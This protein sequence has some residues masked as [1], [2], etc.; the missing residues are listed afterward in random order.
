VN[1]YNRT[2]VGLDVH[3][4]TIVT[5]VLP[6]WSE[7]VTETARVENTREVIEKLV[8]RLGSQGAVEFVYEAGPCGYEVQRQIQNLG[9]SCFVVAPGLIPV[10][11]GDRVKTDRKDAEKLARLWRAGELTAIRVPSHEEEACRDLVRLREDALADRLRAR[12][13]L[14]KFLLRQG[15][16]YRETKSW[17]VTH[18]AWLHAQKFPWEVL[19]RTFEGYLRAVQESEARLGTADQQVLELAESKRYRTMVKYLC[20]FK[21]IQTLSAITLLVESQDLRRFKS[22]PAFMNYTGLTGWEY[23]SADHIR[24]GGISKAGNAHL[25]RVL[26]ESAWSYRRFNVNGAA[27]LERRKGCPPEIVGLARKAQDRL[28]RRFQRLT[29]KGK[30]LPVAVIAIAR[31]LSGFVW[32]M[33]RYFPQAA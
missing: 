5:G 10:R 16:I 1:H 9:Q 19:Q 17:G 21:G 33:S 12:H 3:K 31:E 8:K 22:A 25:R 7:K 32:A 15:R 29:G 11:A 13:R 26:V 20:C 4:E 14:G 24:R 30:S 2:V 28:H 23:S 18:R 27:L 6:G